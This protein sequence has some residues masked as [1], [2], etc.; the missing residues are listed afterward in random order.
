M[1][2]NF[3]IYTV[4]AVTLLAFSCKP[5]CDLDKPKDVKPVD[6]ENYNDVYTVYWNFVAKAFG[7]CSE[8]EF[9]GKT[10]KVFGWIF[11]GNHGDSFRSD[12]FIWLYNV[13][14]G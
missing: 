11:H 5:S 4:C 8:T 7:C 13:L 3:K 14:Y 2:F 6:W 12:R 9:A 10:I 1:N